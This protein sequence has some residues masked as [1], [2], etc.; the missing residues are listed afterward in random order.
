[1]RK[2]R[3]NETDARADPR[4]EERDFAELLAKADAYGEAC[5]RGI[6]V[7]RTRDDLIVAT[8]KLARTCAQSGRIPKV[9][10]S[11]A[12][13]PPNFNDLFADYPHLTIEDVKACLAYAEQ[14]IER[15]IASKR[16]EDITAGAPGV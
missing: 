11:R 2:E 4:A 5:D 16:G 12:P 13:N 15:R 14:A 3:W 10:A 7:Y 6:G 1:M 9:G 8:L